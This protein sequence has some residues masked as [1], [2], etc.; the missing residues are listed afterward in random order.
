MDL[1]RSAASLLALT[2]I[3]LLA[4]TPAEA[5]FGSGTQGPSAQL[6]GGRA[7]D[8]KREAPKRL[9]PSQDATK[10]LREAPPP[11]KAKKP[12]DDDDDEAPKAK[13]GAKKKADTAAIAKTLDAAAKQVAT[14][15][16]EAA[17]KAV[18]GV[19]ATPD[20]PAG[21]MARALYLRGAAH[22]KQGRA[23]QAIADL[24]SALSLRNGL[25]TNDRADAVQ[26]RSA[27]Y[28]EA[29]V[30]EPADATP[31]QRTATPGKDKPNVSSWQTGSTGKQRTEGKESPPATQ[32][33]PKGGGL[34]SF[35]GNLFGGGEAPKREPQ[36]T[37]PP[38]TAVPTWETEVT[39]QK[40]KR[41]RSS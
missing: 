2:C 33:P 30:Q 31:P 11:A 39:P 22:R 35:F 13:A 5:Q 41:D 24:T 40:A 23:G 25:T 19:L 10:P 26:Q 3:W 28:R 21:L 17:I 37:A 12:A 38:K 27:A 8:N 29:G 16:A 20:L 9:D 34:G 32:E 4:I 15:K 36:P 6:P 7:G 14:N 1:I 18:N